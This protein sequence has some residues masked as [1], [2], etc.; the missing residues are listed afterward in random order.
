MSFQLCMGAHPSTVLAYAQFMSAALLLA[1]AFVAT[2]AGIACYLRI[3]ARFG[4]VAV[5]NERTLHAKPTIRGGGIVIAA[6][7]CL[8]VIA[9]SDLPAASRYAPFGG[10]AAI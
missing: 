2:L 9:W 6:V 1:V 10:S 7:F 3:A 8:A 5:P 4:I